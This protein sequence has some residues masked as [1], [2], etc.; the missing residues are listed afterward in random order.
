MLAYI[1]R[2]LLLIIPMV[3]GMLTILFV[4]LH[5]AP[6]D[7]AASLM[8]NP[9][10][11][12]EAIEL[13]RAKWHLDEPIWKQFLVWVSNFLQGDMGESLHR[14]KTVLAV[15]A[16]FL[17]NTIILSVVSVI[18]IFVT[19]IVV[20]T[21]QAVKQYSF[22]DNAL[23]TI[24][25]FLYSMPSF[26]LAL[27]LVLIF[28]LRFDLFPDHGMHDIRFLDGAPEGGGFG[29]KLGWYWRFWMDSLHHLLL[30][31]FALG[32]AP[33]AGIARFMR[34]SLLEVL[35]QD[36]VRT[37]RAKGL[38]PGS[39]I[40]K[41]ALR[42]SLLTVI[43]LFGLTLPFLFGGAVLIES[44]FAWP[45]MGRLIVESI[46]VRDYPVV[47]ANAFF[48]GLLVMLGNLVADVLY[49]VVDPRIRYS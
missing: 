23:T 3:L 15:I 38:H 24:G 41:H 31:S 32:I 46:F 40:F 6:G 2:R 45:G 26:W 9:D 20:G 34:T 21:I 29:E 27:M 42:N 44:V 25:L 19:G 16:D 12:P 1:A 39:V 48:I 7:P 36:Y 18:L 33:A 30:P 5:L 35:S 43:T 47:M 4:I 8:S 11:P 10:L 49:A 14:N 28:S 22:I 13:F 37:A 17:P